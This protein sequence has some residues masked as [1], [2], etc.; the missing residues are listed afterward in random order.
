MYVTGW[1]LTS[2]RG[3]GHADEAADSGKNREDNEGNRHNPRRFVGLKHVRV[4][5]VSV[6][7]FT[8]MLVVNLAERSWPQNVMTIIRVCRRQ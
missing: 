6:G 1:S 8:V 4:L 7:I 2:D 3:I 5:G